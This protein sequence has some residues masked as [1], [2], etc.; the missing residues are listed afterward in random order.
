[1]ANLPHL[2][3]GLYTFIPAIAW[4]CLSFWL[5]TMPGSN[6]PHE[7]WFDVLQVDK[8]VHVA[9]FFI[10][11]F[12]FMLP[13]KKMQLSA[14]AYLPWQLLITVSAILYGVIMEFVQRDF[15]ANR[16]FDVWDIAADA[17]GC[18]A[19]FFWYRKRSAVK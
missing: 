16:S 6:I 4:L 15:I 18:L 10:L 14:G 17:L 12:L 7:D 1:M 5:L 19:A 11:C 2:K 8:C 9:M 13:I 3:T